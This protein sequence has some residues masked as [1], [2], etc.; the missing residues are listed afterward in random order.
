MFG[1]MTLKEFANT[2]SILLA[3]LKHKINYEFYI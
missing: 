2:K 1:L 3:I